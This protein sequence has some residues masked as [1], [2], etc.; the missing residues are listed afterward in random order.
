[1]V[2]EHSRSCDQCLNVIIPLYATSVYNTVG[3][4]CFLIDYCRSSVKL[5]GGEEMF[6]GYVPT[7]SHWYEVL[8]EKTVQV[9][10]ELLESFGP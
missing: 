10:L 5:S 1:M 9:W 8:L 3:T 6:P 7:V 2:S 4:C